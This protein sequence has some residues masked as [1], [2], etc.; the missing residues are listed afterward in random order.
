MGADEAAG[1]LGMEM[2]EELVRGD[3]GEWTKDLAELKEE[4]GDGDGLILKTGEKVC[5]VTAHFN[6]HFL[7][8]GRVCGIAQ[9]SPFCQWKF[10]GHPHRD[11]SEARMW[12]LFHGKYTEQKGEPKGVSFQ[13]LFL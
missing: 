13:F 10:T 9:A 5:N 7:E 4:A 2:P 11:V 6:G 8:D 1:N 3:H 12:T